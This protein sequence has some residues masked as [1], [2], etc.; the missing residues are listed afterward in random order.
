M[1]LRKKKESTLYCEADLSKSQNMSLNAWYMEILI[2][3]E[4]ED[5]RD[6]KTLGRRG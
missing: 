6:I 4:K 1:R 2:F 3:I 5:C